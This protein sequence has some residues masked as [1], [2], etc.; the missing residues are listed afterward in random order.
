MTPPTDKAGHTKRIEVDA[1]FELA[2]WV[3][4]DKKVINF[5]AKKYCS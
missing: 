1:Q 2:G 4:H 3:L 5:Y